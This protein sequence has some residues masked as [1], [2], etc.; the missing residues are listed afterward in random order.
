MRKEKDN[1]DQ[2]INKLIEIRQA[3][4]QN[5][6]TRRKDAQFELLDALVLKDQIT[7]FPMLNCSTA[8]SRRWQSA[9]AAVES[10]QQDQAWLRSY[11]TKQVPEEGIQFFLWIALHGQDR[12]RI[13]FLTG[14]MY[15]S[16]AGPTR[17]QSS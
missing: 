4:Y 3:V 2:L 13:P 10:G 8:F 15:I 14:S 12:K 5:G 17:G 9:Y 1:T 11:L 7:S 6:F 16:Q